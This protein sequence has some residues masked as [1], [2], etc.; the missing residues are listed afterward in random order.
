MLSL[1][2]I[3][4]PNGI[5]SSSQ[6]NNI[7]PNPAGYT[8]VGGVMLG[9]NGDPVLQ[10]SPTRALWVGSIPSQTTPNHLMDIFSPYGAIE[11]VR[12]LSHKNCGCQ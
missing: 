1:T 12:V 7:C 4:G 10:S 6:I 2:N 9:P 3:P 5:V 11:S 8:N